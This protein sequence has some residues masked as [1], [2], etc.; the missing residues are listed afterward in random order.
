[1][2]AKAEDA[3]TIVPDWVSELALMADAK[4]LASAA[5][6]IGYSTA[7]VSQ[8]I[9]AK[10]P[11]DLTKVED[12]VRGALMGL[13]VICPVLGEIGRD[14]CLSQQAKPFAATNSTRTRVYRAC[15]SGCLHSG[16]KG[17][18]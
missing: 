3:W 5:G 13:T 18:A 14:Y 6:R 7:V 12:K 9:G 2:A 15:R 8:V 10:Y 4:G 16:L 17:R 1:M 11:G